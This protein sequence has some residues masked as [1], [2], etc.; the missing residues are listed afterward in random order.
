MKERQIMIQTEQNRT[1]NRKVNSDMNIDY[2]MLAAKYF[3][4]ILNQVQSSCLNFQI[5]LSPFGAII[6]LKK[7]FVRDKTGSL[8]IPDASTFKNK[9]DEF[10][11]LALKNLELQEQNKSLRSE[12]DKIKGDLGDA[13][14]AVELI[15]N[16]KKILEKEIKDFGGIKEDTE[17]N[18]DGNQKDEEFTS[19]STLETR[20]ACQI[21][22]SVVNSTPPPAAASWSSPVAL[23]STPLDSLPSSSSGSQK[24]NVNINNMDDLDLNYN[25]KVSNSFSPLQK[26]SDAS[27]SIPAPSKN[28]SLSPARTKN[29]QDQFNMSFNLDSDFSKMKQVLATMTKTSEENQKKLEE[30]FK[31]LFNEE[32][33]NLG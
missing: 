31:K 9:D 10:A 1:M 33:L 19:P 21:S 32:S 28:P 2:T 13:Q 5:Q 27:S 15:G 14:K 23:N 12:Y 22:H 6:S 7:S 16:E 4:G 3:D 24:T 20:T 25:V 29:N 11:A 30:T 18:A 26:V 17:K 8:I